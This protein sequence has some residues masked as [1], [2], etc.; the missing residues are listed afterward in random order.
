MWARKVLPRVASGISPNSSAAGNVCEAEA[1]K[2]AMKDRRWRRV[3][4]SAQ[5]TPPDC[6]PPSPR[7]GKP[8]PHRCTLGQTAAAA[9]AIITLEAGAETYRR[10]I[11]TPIGV[12]CAPGNPFFNLVSRLR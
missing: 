1:C 6:P 2:A 8:D 5:V 11:P 12:A 7:D 10:S 9:A 3:G 4:T